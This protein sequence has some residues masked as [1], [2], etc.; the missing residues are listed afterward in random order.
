MAKDE[1]SDEAEENVYKEN[2]REDLVD[3]DE[4]SPEEEAFMKGYDEASSSDEILKDETKEEPRVEEE[5][6]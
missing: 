1:N 3:N 2:T 5:E 4:L 6:D